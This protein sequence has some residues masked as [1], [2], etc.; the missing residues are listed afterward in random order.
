M[1]TNVLFFFLA[2]KAYVAQGSND[3]CRYDS[4]DKMKPFEFPIHVAV[5]GFSRK[6]FWV[7]PV[8][9][10]KTQLFQLLCIYVQLQKMV[11]V[12]FF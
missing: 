12:P 1:V 10:N 8:R 4:Y 11:V 5:Y 7:A 9:S 6:V 3:V 2:P